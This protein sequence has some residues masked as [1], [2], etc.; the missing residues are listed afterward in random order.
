MGEIVM[1]CN[2]EASRCDEYQGDLQTGFLNLQSEL[3]GTLN[4]TITVGIG[5]C[6][7][8][9]AGILDSY[10]EAAIA[11]KQK[12]KLGL[13]KIIPWNPEFNG[14]TYYYPFEVEEQIRNYLDLELRKETMDKI[15]EL[16]EDLKVRKKLS[17]ENIIQIL[18]QLVGNTIIKY[19]IEHRID[20]E[21]V[22]ESSINTNIYAEIFQKD[23]LDGIKEVLVEKYS[24]LIDY[25]MMTR[26]R[27]SNA[28]KIVEYIDSNYKKDIG[29]DDI[30]EHVGMSY[31]H[32]RRVFKM[33]IGTNIVDYIN[34]MRIREAR[35]LLLDK[36]L[37][38][39]NIAISLGYNN[40][41][42]FERYFKK[43]MGVTPGEYRSKKGNPDGGDSHHA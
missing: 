7:T 43:F 10:M 16:I 37:S 28:E 35:D 9:I 25:S 18:T 31:S 24:Q 36:E 11:T 12:M 3:V 17:C 26:N 8:D 27:K 38:I 42:S 1:I 6:Y 5:G 33:E 40:H 19:M 32:V 2:V 15:E 23:T 14:T 34:S 39:K 21:D 13:G 29:I 22:Y 30:S 41:Q 20:F 4:S